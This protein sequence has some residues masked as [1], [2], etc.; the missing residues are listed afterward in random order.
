MAALFYWLI[1]RPLL[2]LALAAA[3]LILVL[4]EMVRRYRCA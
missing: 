1:F 3:G 2:R 4:I